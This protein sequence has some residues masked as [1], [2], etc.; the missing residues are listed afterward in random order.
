MNR[1]LAPERRPLLLA[2]GAILATSALNLSAPSVM[3]HAID[4]PLSDG[5]YAGVLRHVGLLFAMYLLSLFTQHRQTLLMGSVGQ[6]VLFGLRG[7][8]FEKLQQLSVAFF[9]RHRTGDLISRINNDTDKVH[10][11]YSQSLMQFVGSFVTMVGS[12]FFL[13]GLNPRL[14]LAALVPAVAMFGLTRLLNP[15]IRRRNAS[16]QKSTGQVSAEIAESLSHF[17]VMV[18]FDRRDY[19]RQ[20]FDQVNRQNYGYALKAG[21]ANGVLAPLF[22][23]C[24]QLGQLI[25]L[26]VGLAMVARGE[27]SLGLLISYFVYVNRFYDPMRQLAALWASFQAASAAYE[28]ISEVLADQSTMKVVPRDDSAPKGHSGRMEFR[29]VTF[30]YRPDQEVLRAIDFQLDPGKTYAFVGPTGGGKTTTASL[31]ARLYD[32]LAGTVLLDGY[33]L[34]TYSDQERSQKIG[35]ILQ[36]PYLFGSTVGDNISSLEGLERL[37][38]EGLD[39]PVE[40]LSL[41]QRQ[42]VAFL[43]AVL[44]QPD[45]LILDEATANIDTVTETILA[46]LLGR[47]PAHTTRVVIA[48]RLSTIES[49]DTIFFVNAGRIQMAGSMEQA[50]ALL[51]D[52]ARQ[53]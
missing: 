47:L 12:G 49:A 25:V 41:G 39:T 51:R 48:H 24:S 52:E 20:N 2:A 40:G 7:E 33:D 44:R 35:F 26:T 10:Q 42:V 38:P 3:A 14:G 22:G 13:V 17:K 34:R 9:D 23:L 21:L 37:F 36:D 53:S 19:F 18:A 16:N 5:D 50:V 43:R 30:G 45:L 46:G 4:G 15:W 32:P 8:V 29:G 31:M 28:R 11:F 1:L 6:R 27:F